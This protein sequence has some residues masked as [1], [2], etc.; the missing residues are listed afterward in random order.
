MTNQA[1]FEIVLAKQAVVAIRDLDEGKSV[2]NDAER[3]VRFL[4]KQGMLPPGRRL[5]Y[6]DTMGRW[7]ELEHDGAGRFTGFHPI[8]K[9]TI[10]GALSHIGALYSE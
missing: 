9:E 8:G 2:T 7:D 10:E 3:V 6:Q 1:K 4:H 5:I